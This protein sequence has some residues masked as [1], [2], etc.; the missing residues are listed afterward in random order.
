MKKYLYIV[1]LLILS[2]NARAAYSDSLLYHPDANAA[3]DITDAIKQAK[4]E[5]KHVLIMAG[6]NWCS[7]CH[8]FN[9]LATADRQV[10]SLVK[11]NYI[12]YHLNY[13]PENKNKAV[14]DHYGFPQRFG[15]PVFIVLDADGNRIHTQNSGYLEQ[16]NYYSK[17]K[18]MDFLRNWSPKA[19]K[20]ENYN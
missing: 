11:A 19:L 13:S 18:V 7:W 14:F 20:A 3:A 9:R 10:D 15:F 2:L 1:F 16:N 8:K 5:N 17:P 12:V 6:G 4:A